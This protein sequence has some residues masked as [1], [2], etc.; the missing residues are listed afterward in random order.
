MLVGVSVVHVMVW[1]GPVR[2]VGWFTCGPRLCWGV[3]VM[4][5]VGVAAVLGHQVAE[6]GNGGGVLM[7]LVVPHPLA[8]RERRPLCNMELCGQRSLC[9]LRLAVLVQGR[10]AAVQRWWAASGSVLMVVCCEDLELGCCDAAGPGS[11]LG[12]H[13]L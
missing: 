6:V 1:C 12:C 13:A 10:S 3:L 9:G 5:L 4:E 2:R 8:L 11:E 7:P